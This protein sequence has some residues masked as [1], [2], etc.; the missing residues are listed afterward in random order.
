MDSAKKPL[1]LVWKN[2]DPMAK[3]INYDSNAVIFK[4]GDDLR[5]DMLTLQVIKIIDHIW[6]DHEGLDLRYK[7][8]Q[9][10]HKIV[11]TQKYQ[12]PGW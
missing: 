7:V 11:V 12:S 2:N 5:Q 8:C 6:R 9:M 4:N 10:H 3:D 1:W